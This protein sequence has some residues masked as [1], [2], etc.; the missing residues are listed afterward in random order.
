MK[1]IKELGVI[2]CVAIAITLGFAN[3]ACGQ[4]S[5]I[6]IEVTVPSRDG[7]EVGLSKLVKGIASVPAGHHVW[8]LVRR[9]DFKGVWWPQGEAI[10]D[11]KTKEWKVDVTF[12]QPKV[13]GWNFDL[14]A[15]IVNDKNHI[16]LRNYRIKA[17]TTGNWVPI[18][19]PDTVGAPVVRKV[20]KTS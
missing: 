16:I 10:I 12:G 4:E 17:L 7:V 3:S 20:K 8:V 19:M 13:V 2:M 14:A 5:D 18:Q 11:P 1:T 9:E 15:A 6:A